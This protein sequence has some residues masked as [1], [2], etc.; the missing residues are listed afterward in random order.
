MERLNDD[1]CCGGGCGGRQWRVIEGGGAVA[2]DAAR[3]IPEDYGLAA[4]DLR[5]W[6]S[7]GRAGAVLALLATLGMA[8]TEAFSGARYSDPWILGAL[9]GLLYG[10]LIGGF[11][12]LGLLVLVHWCDPLIG[13][14]WPQYARLRRYRDA[15]AAARAAEERDGP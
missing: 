13:M 14:A 1:E 7:P 12:G 2:R 15:L 4:A 6:Y 5:I 10:G 9:G 3:P 11:G 8:S